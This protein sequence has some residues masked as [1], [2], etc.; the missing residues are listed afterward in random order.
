MSAPTP[1]SPEGDPFSDGAELACLESEFLRVWDVLGPDESRRRLA[2]LNDEVYRMTDPK[3]L[4]NGLV[5]VAL[6]VGGCPCL[7]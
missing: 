3:E 4:R 7:S 6:F 1:K 2:V 5:S